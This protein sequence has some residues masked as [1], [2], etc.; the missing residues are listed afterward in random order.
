MLIRESAR[1]QYD[2]RDLSFICD[3]S[4]TADGSCLAK[5]G[6]TQI[7]C[8][9]QI[10]NGEVPFLFEYQGNLETDHDYDDSYISFFIHK[11]LGATLSLKILGK[12]TLKIS[13][14]ILENEGGVCSAAISGSYIAAILALKRYVG[15]GYS[16]AI[17]P[18]AGIS[19]GFIKGEML[20]DLDREEKAQAEVCADVVFT[21]QGEILSSCLSCQKRPL[22]TAQWIQ[23]SDLAFYGARRIFDSQNIFL[24]R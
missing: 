22:T 7:L 4:R 17:Q 10:I 2:L 23:L 15:D 3:I 12:K 19:C 24:S 21:C 13:C 9:A 1:G 5:I 14:H 18:L 20:L 6:Y 11:A 16:K 8:K